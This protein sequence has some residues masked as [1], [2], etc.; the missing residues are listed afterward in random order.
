MS[1]SPRSRW[2]NRDESSYQDRKATSDSRKNK[3]LRRWRMPTGDFSAPT[4]LIGQITSMLSLAMAYKIKQHSGGILDEATQWTQD[5]STVLVT[6][7][8]GLFSFLLLFR[9]SISRKAP[10]WRKR[11]ARIWIIG[12]VAA[13]FL[14]P[15]Y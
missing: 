7:L 4:L 3:H 2:S 9:V 15:S 13:F 10:K 1:I 11:I 6:V 5:G 12:S 8:F 14:F